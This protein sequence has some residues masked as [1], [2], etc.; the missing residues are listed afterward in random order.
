MIL[1]E[2]R[3]VTLT[4]NSGTKPS[5]A[6]CRLVCRNSKRELRR[7]SVG[8]VPMSLS[9]VTGASDGGVKVLLKQ[10]RWT[11]RHEQSRNRK[12]SHKLHKRK[13][14]EERH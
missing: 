12:M 3:Q 6:E 9:L 14:Q 1:S 10:R 7:P 8:K 5:A 2:W 13:A 11:P 4:K